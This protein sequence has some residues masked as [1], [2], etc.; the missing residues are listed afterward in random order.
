MN[1]LTDEQVIEACKM[2]ELKRKVNA[3]TEKLIDS[4][5][6]SATVCG[7]VFTGAEAEWLKEQM[8]LRKMK[9]AR[10]INNDNFHK[11]GVGEFIDEEV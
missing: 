1:T 5:S 3:I 4:P 8:I 2:V 6:V 9:Q 11:Y 10:D 7:I